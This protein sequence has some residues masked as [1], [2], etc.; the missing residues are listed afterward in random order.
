MTKETVVSI[1]QE[2]ILQIIYIA[3]PVLIVALIVGLVIA[4][5]QAITSIQEQTLTFV[6]K[7]LAILGMI[8]LL[9]SWMLST[10]S[11]YVIRLFNMI[12][13]MAM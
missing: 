13:S 4:L 1:L 8:A 12:P 11:E 7:I 6:P 9:G 3:G 10:L 5:F 2:G